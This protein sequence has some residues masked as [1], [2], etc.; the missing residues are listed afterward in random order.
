MSKESGCW[1]LFGVEGDS[2]IWEWVYFFLFGLVVV[3]DGGGVAKLTEDGE[4]ERERAT[5]R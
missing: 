2:P 5:E 1:K 3:G 4:R